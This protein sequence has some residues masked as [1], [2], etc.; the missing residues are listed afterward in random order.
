LA[1]LREIPEKFDGVRW[2]RP[3]QR[4]PSLVGWCG[5]KSRKIA[6]QFGL[7]SGE[8]LQEAVCDDPELDVAMVGG[9]LSPGGVSVSIGFAV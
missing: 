9:D 1:Q 3:S 2:P 8:Y 4:A 6:N 5:S 7:H